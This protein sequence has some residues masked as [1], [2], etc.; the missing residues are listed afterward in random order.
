MLH[1]LLFEFDFSLFYVYDSW[2]NKSKYPNTMKK[3]ILKFHY[4]YYMY[5]PIKYF[6]G[7]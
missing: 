7:I 3:L 6:G 4:L 1:F 5:I 2:I